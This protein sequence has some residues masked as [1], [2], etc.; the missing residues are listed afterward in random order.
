MERA[1]TSAWQE[2][3]GRCR[4]ELGAVHRH[5]EAAGVSVEL[6]FD[7]KK[8]EACFARMESLVAVLCASNRADSL[9]ATRHLL[10]SLWRADNLISA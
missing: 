5:M 3:V 9:R 6:V 4:Q 2:V 7:L 8:I 1:G 10:E